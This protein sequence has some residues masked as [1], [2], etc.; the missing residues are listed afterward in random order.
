MKVGENTPYPE[1]S[2]K[3]RHEIENLSNICYK[4]KT[5]TSNLIASQSCDL[6]RNLFV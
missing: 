4:M 2:V 3:D 6:N 5:D 1:Q